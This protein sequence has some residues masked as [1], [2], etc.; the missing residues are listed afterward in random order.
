MQVLNE[1]YTNPELANICINGI[2]GTHFEIKDEEKGI[3]GFPEGVDGT[4]TGYPSLPV[5]VAERDDLLRLGG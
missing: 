2:E 5:G 4:T 3:V 1:I